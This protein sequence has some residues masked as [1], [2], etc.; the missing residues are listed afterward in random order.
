VIN[1]EGHPALDEISL[2][3]VLTFTLAAQLAGV[4]PNW[5]GLYENYDQVWQVYQ[6][7]RAPLAVN[8]ISRYLRQGGEGDAAALLP[9]A[10]GQPFA[11]ANG[12][13]WALVTAQPERQKVA[14][15]LAEFLV[16]AAYL[17]TWSSAAG[18]LPTR[19]TAASF[20]ND[21]DRALIAQVVAAAVA[22]PSADV[23]ASVNPLLAQAMLQVFKQQALPE[24]AARQAADALRTPK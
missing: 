13:M 24:V 22:Y 9:T 23:T 4:M 6:E 10:D 20:S 12:W 8:W 16:E 17:D 5:L 3:R 11:Q 15:A 7:R 1:D 19:S 14:A 18:Y 2:T 21:P